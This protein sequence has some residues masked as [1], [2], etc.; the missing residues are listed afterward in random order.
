MKTELKA[1]GQ[2]DLKRQQQYDRLTVREF[3]CA[4]G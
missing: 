4:N 1:G 2:S 3:H